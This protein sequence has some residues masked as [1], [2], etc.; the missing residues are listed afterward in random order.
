MKLPPCLLQLLRCKG[1]ERQITFPTEVQ[2]ARLPFLSVDPHTF[3][4]R[5]FV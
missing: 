5:L 1:D 2:E 3:V 4:N